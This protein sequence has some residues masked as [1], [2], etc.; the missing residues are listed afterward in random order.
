MAGSFQLGPLPR[1]STCSTLCLIDV[2][3]LVS[4]DPAIPAATGF[5]SAQRTWSTTFSVF[6]ESN[7]AVTR[8]CH[9]RKL[10][11][12]PATPSAWSKGTW[13]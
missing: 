9:K 11:R 12:P 10:H 13:T 4:A 1:T 3:L 6:G 5:R 7:S 2:Y 8:V